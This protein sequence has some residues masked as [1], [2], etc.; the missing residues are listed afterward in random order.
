MIGK[1]SLQCDMFDVGNVFPIVLR[2]KSFHAQ[3]AK[4][5]P[6]LFSDDEF[7]A[8]YSSSLGRPSVPP[9]QLAI[10][11][12]LQWYHGVSDLETVERSGCDLRWCAVLN[13]AAGEALCAKST[14]QMFRA[15][16]I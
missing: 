6:T 12:L 2:E 5:A 1:R 14:F 3:L 11:M 9:S 7:A 13:R 10:L 16:L 15:Q 8:L 4:A